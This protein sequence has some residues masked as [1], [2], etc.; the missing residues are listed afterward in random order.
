VIESVRMTTEV[1]QREMSPELHL[2]PLNRAK[3][4]RPLST[5][6]RATTD[7]DLARRADSI[8]ASLTAKSV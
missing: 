3:S 5:L 6:H 1:H 8:H 2:V 4:S 7:P